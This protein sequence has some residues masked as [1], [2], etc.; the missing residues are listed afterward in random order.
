MIKKESVHKIHPTGLYMV[1]ERQKPLPEVTE[2]GII[3][4][5][6][7]KHEEYKPNSS[8]S[9]MIVDKEIE[10]QDNLQ[11]SKVISVGPEVTAFKKG[12]I[13]ITNKYAGIDI[14]LDHSFYLIHI[15]DIL[16]TIK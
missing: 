16:A 12:E 1:I 6:G 7:K 3:L 9:A 4:S 5:V 13:V 14:F 10:E 11:E 8:N 2:S 15:K